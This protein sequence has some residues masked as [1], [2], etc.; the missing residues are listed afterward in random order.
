[1]S[2]LVKARRPTKGKEE[3]TEVIAACRPVAIA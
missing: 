2:G 3:A 1:M